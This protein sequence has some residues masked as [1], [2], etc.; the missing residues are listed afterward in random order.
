M[1][2]EDPDLKE[3]CDNLGSSMVEQIAARNYV[4]VTVEG[5]P[6]YAI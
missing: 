1:R 4:A 3:I 6:L 5:R 2:V